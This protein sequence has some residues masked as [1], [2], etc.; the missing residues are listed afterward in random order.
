ME[1]SGAGAFP[2]DFSVDELHA[3]D[4][5]RD[6]QSVRPKRCRSN[7]PEEGFRAS[8]AINRSRVDVLDDCVVVTDNDGREALNVALG[9]FRKQLLE[10]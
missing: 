2:F 3:G 5:S 10:S 7:K 9:K 1:D 4:E 6:E 8:W